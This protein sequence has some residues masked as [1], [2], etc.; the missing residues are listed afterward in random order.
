VDGEGVWEKVCGGGG[1]GVNLG[2]RVVLSTT[3]PLLVLGRKSAR[4]IPYLPTVGVGS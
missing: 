1:G 3:R 4:G 2:P